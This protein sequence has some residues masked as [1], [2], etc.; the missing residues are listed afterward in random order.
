[1]LQLVEAHGAL[2]EEILRGTFPTWH[3]QLSWEAYGRFWRAQLKTPWG[4]TRLR[5]VALVDGPHLLASLKIYDFDAVLD[6]RPVG[7]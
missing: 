4:R 3:D 2:L 5:R 7:V 6:G 1:M